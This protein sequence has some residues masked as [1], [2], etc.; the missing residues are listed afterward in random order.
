MISHVIKLKILVVLVLLLCNVA[1]AQETDPTRPKIVEKND[2]QLV[3]TTPLVS[4][5][6]PT[7]DVTSV[8]VTPEQR[9]AVVNGEA[10]QERETKQQ[11]LLFAVSVDDV[12]FRLKEKTKVIT[13]KNALVISEVN[14]EF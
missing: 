7:L 8:V 4:D 10:W 2:E 13:L 3:L 5:G 14:D 1:K 12:T 11:V 9:Y 6:F